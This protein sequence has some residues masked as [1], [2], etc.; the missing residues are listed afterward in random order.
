MCECSWCVTS[1]VS[2]IWVLNPSIVSLAVGK[3][4]ACVVT[5]LLWG[6]RKGDA[7][8]GKS[9]AGCRMSSIVMMWRAKCYGGEL[10]FAR[11]RVMHG[12]VRGDDVRVYISCRLTCWAS[13]HGFSRRNVGKLWCAS[14]CCVRETV[15]KCLKISVKTLHFQI[16]FVYLPA[17]MR[18]TPSCARRVTG[19]KSLKVSRIECNKAEIDNF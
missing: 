4:A 9:H 1:N 19:V 10:W 11:D 5:S 6:V 18:V 12:V 14:I 17:F 8:W 15:C 7:L 2:L 13:E 3:S 16:F